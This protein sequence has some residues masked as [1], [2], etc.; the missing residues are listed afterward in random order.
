MT[1]PAEARAILREKGLCGHV[2]QEYVTVGDATRLDER[3]CI[4]PIGHDESKHE[5][6]GGVLVCVLSMPGSIA[7][8]AENL[9]EGWILAD[10]LESAA[11]QAELSHV[12]PLADE[13]R[14]IPLLIGKRT[15]STGHVLIVADR[16]MLP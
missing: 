15:L 4:L 12:Q 11:R 6:G 13:L 2:F 14:R 16:R 10:S 1:T 5:A 7:R 9:I 3:I 8:N